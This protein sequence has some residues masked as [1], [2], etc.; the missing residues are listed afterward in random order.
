MSEGWTW[1]PLLGMGLWVVAAFGTPLLCFE[2]TRDVGQERILRLE[3]AAR[4]WT[5]LPIL[6]VQ[7][8]EARAT[9]PTPDQVAGRVVFRGLFGMPWA[10]VVREDSGQEDVTWQ[11]HRQMAVWGMFVCALLLLAFWEWWL[12]RR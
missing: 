10:E 7:T 9:G 2:D 3:T 1:A 5:K 4:H 12:L 11:I 8:V 6:K